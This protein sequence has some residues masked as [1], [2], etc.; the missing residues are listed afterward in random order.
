[1][2]IS[3]NNKTIIP[4]EAIALKSSLGKAAQ[5]FICK[6]YIVNLSKGPLGTIVI[7]TNELI[8][9]IGAVSPTALDIARIIPLIIPPIE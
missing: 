3:I 5:V 1:M 6:G 2:V 8:I 4:V 7:N 9:R